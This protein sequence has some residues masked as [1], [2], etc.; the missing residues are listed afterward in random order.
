M[1]L[2]IC[3]TLS[4]RN[5]H[6][7][8]RQ[9]MEWKGKPLKQTPLKKIRQKTFR[10]WVIGSEDLCGGTITDTR[11]KRGGLQGL[12]KKNFV[13]VRTH[14]SSLQSDQGSFS[15]SVLRCIGF[16]P[17]KYTIGASGTRMAEPGIN[18]SR[19][20]RQG[21]LALGELGQV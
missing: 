10:R 15:K 1:T 4:L 12:F 9:K 19:V 8:V 20:R 21:H 16:W 11:E 14:P 7:F 6:R 18:A 17:T 13:K 2:G 3:Q 5:G